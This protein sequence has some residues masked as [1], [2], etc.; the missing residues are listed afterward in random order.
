MYS[1]VINPYTNGYALDYGD[2]DVS[3]ERQPSIK[4]DSNTRVHTVLEGETIQS[5]AWKYYGDSG[6]WADI[7]DANLIFNP[8]VELEADMELLIP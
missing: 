8:F 5:I 4:W 2:G 6:R 7:A 1:S 3:L